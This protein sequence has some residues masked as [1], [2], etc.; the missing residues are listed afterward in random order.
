MQRAPAARAAA[1][2]FVAS[3]VDARKIRV[4]PEG[5]N[6]TYYDRAKHRAMPMPQVTSATRDAAP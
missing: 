4:V 5:V 6:T 1:Q 2:V 3:G